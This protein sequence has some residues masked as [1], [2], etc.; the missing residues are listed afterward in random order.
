MKRIL[1]SALALTLLLV[2]GCCS[3][4]AQ[5]A[6][7]TPGVEYILTVETLDS[8]RTETRISDCSQ[9]E[10]IDVQISWKKSG[11]D[12]VAS[13]TVTNNNPDY[14]VK[15]LEGPFVS[16][17]DFDVTEY[18]VLIPRGMGMMVR[19]SPLD[20]RTQAN[21]SRLTGWS[22][23]KDDRACG[24]VTEGMYNICSPYP[25]L[26]MSMGW[27]AFAGEDR[28]VYVSSHDKNLTGKDFTVYFDPAD[29]TYKVALT[30]KFTCFSG[31]TYNVPETRVREYKG[32]WHKAADY[33][34]QWFDTVIQMPQQP[35]WL[36]ESSGWMLAISKQQNDEVMYSYD[37]YATELAD[38]T[39]ERGLDIVGLFG[40][41][42]GGH[43][44]FYPYYYPDPMRG[45]EEELRKGIKG[46][47]DRGLRVIMYVNGQLLDQ[48]GTDYWEK[49]GKHVTLVNKKGDYV[50]QTWHKYYDAPARTHGVACFCCEDWRERML[51][52][53]K[54][55]Q[56]YG[57][58][59]IIYDQLAT[60]PT[61]FCY[62][63]EHGHTVPALVVDQ[64]KREFIGRI[65]E[66]MYAIDP[67]FVIMTEGISDDEFQCINF[68]HGCSFGANPP[69]QL[70]FEQRCNGEG[71]V[72]WF[73]EMIAYT[74]PE[75]QMTLRNP[76]PVTSRNMSN[77]T[78]VC[79]LKNELE[80][81]YKADVRYLREDHIPV[82]EDYSNVTTKPNLNMVT[83]EDPVAMKKYQ[84]VLADFQTENM[85]L[86]R[87]GRFMDTLGFTYEGSHEYGMAKAFET[88]G[89]TG[90]VVWNISRTDP[91]SWKVD[92]P[93][94][95]LVKVTAPD[96][97]AAQGKPVP[98]ESILL[99]IY[100]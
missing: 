59:G 95:K 5:N 67:E 77:Y 22:K 98:P 10:G 8:A 11:G 100:E 55:I 43:D 99:L 20:K 3:F 57:A 1:S 44:R 28:G 7:I 33:Y 56:S 61:A 79:H 47:K 88:E 46:L 36:K 80:S 87:L 24:P 78:L 37:E 45:D 29:T 54:Q 89:K 58:D 42:H 83:T 50:A 84:K 13:A 26:S 74:F 4:T 52:L 68:F 90:I 60:R 82:P 34:R 32:T 76:A 9:I 96:W 14:V 93:G 17:L 2:S 27:I 39:L 25:S 53:A 64:D 81:R 91:L 15:S 73:P 30:H 86:L 94:K 19:K 66:E 6:K 18:P 65:K 69:S 75:L 21:F 63:P 49:T 62:S 51:N 72:T 38:Q 31:N 16:G 48:N 92:V 70:A 12:L 97:D 41:A 40:W 85:D 71:R 23:V 35:Q